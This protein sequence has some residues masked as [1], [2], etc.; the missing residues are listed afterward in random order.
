MINKLEMKEREKQQIWDNSVHIQ[1]NRDPMFKPYYER[2]AE[3]KQMNSRMPIN[4][5]QNKR[6]SGVNKMRR[7]TLE[8]FEQNRQTKSNQK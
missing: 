2:I 1:I 6:L 5:S 4:R 8:N 3:S 7:E